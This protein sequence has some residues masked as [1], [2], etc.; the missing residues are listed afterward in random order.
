MTALKVEIAGVQTPVFLESTGPKIS[1]SDISAFE[2]RLGQKLPADYRE[3]LLKYNGGSPLVGVVNGRDD[4]PNIPYQYGDAVRGFFKL[5]AGG[6]E[7]PEYERLTLPS[8]IPWDLPKDIFPIADDA[9]GN[10]FVMQLGDPSG[11]IRFLNHEDDAPIDEHRVV[12]DSFLDLLLRFRSLEEQAAIDAA[13]KES[14][15]RR[16]MNGPF[17]PK[18]DAQCRVVELNNPEVRA[19]IRLV[20]LGLFEAKGHFSIHAEDLSRLWI[21]LLFWVY[22]TAIAPLRPIKRAELATIVVNCYRDDDPEGYGLNGYA[23]DFLYEW[24][25]DRLNSGA[26]VPTGNGARLSEA[27]A[28]A[29]FDQLKQMRRAGR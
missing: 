3:F 14:E 18:L 12:A 19:W 16:I 25:D 6:V 20:S 17:P 27:A 7:V 11:C 22:Q 21:D 1:S 29:M 15:R 4:D 2:Q 5:A 9:G 28:T 8:D 24:W 23:P 26:L 10:C 13:E